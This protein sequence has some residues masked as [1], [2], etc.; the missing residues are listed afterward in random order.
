MLNKNKVL[1][2]N[3]SY[4]P[5]MVINI[6]KAIVMYLL[7][8]IEYVE[9]SNFF[10][11]SLYL[12]LPIPHVVKLKEYIFVKRKKI[13]L[14]RQNIL[15]RDGNICQYCGSISKD[16]TIDH[17]IPKDKGGNDSWLNLVAA[18]RKCNFNKG[19]NYLRDTNLKLI[20]SPSKPNYLFYIKNSQN[21]HLSWNKYLF[22]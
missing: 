22:N 7:E 12:Q 15:K 5:L 1:L 19:N 13:A 18:C 14:T 16:M 6:K 11:N 8:K 3:Y 4:E 21:K 2:L 9:K 20:K 10:I 17:I